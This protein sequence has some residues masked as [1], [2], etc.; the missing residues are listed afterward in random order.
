VIDLYDPYAGKD[1]ALS[2]EYIADDDVV[3]DY[4]VYTCILDHTSTAD[5]EPGVGVNW[6]TYWD[7]SGPANSLQTSIYATYT[8][9]PSCGDGVCNGDETHATCPADCPLT[10][11]SAGSTIINTPLSGRFIDSSL[12]GYWSF[13]GADMGVT[14][15][16]DLSGNGNTGT[17]NGGVKKVPG[18]N[19]Q[20]LSFDGVDDYVEM[21]S[22]LVGTGADSF[23]AWI[24]PRSW[25]TP[26]YS[27]VISNLKFQ[28]N[29]IDAGDYLEFT[30]DNNSV[31]NSAYNAISLNTWQHVCAVRDAAGLATIYVNGQVSGTPNQNSGTPTSGAANL[32]IGRGAAYF[33]GLID[34][35]R[36]YNRALS[37][38]E[39]LQLYNSR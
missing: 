25:G 18:I 38:S 14:T 17:L 16:T 30:S 19:G 27:S 5:D 12:V 4:E 29:I 32:R 37:A 39:V 36:I 1:W 26:G 21:S 35:V 10:A 2:T 11:N 34:E 9:A 6:E 24:Y 13:D 8:A 33:P 28:A 20:A 7:H 15:A 22:E 3:N 31:K 23:C